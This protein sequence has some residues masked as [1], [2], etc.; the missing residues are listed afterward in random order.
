VHHDHLAAALPPLA[1][2]LALAA[3]AVG[4]LAWA[5]AA[6]QAGL[7]WKRDA[8]LA[9]LIVLT[10]ID[11]RVFTVG[12]PLNARPIEPFAVLDE[13]AEV[14]LAA[15]MEARVAELEAREGPVRVEVLG[16]GGA[17]QNAPLVIGVE[18]TLGYNPL[19]LADYDTAVGAG[20]NSDSWPA[21]RF[22]TLMTGYRSDFADLLGVRLIALG[23]PMESIDP[24]GAV[25]YGPPLRIGGAWVYENP[26]ALPRVLF[27]GLEGAHPHDPDAL[28]A[29]GGLPA[30]D[31][32]REALIDPLPEPLPETLP[33]AADPSPAGEVRIVARTSDRVDLEVVARRHGF[34]VLHDMAYPGWV[35]HVDGEAQELRRANALFMAAAVP[36]GQHTV[37]FAYEPLTPENLWAMLTGGD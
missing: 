3:V 12:N 20:Q 1:V 32:R 28:V 21:R 9:G 13:P 26:R 4:L 2:A 31:W 18:S 7:L 25:S 27:I 23:A 15:W 8:V 33:A 14:P 11:L 22:G 16:L 6:A 10:L 5:G 37:S 35:V 34:V 17:W 30:L 24:V 19:R 36:A 29:S